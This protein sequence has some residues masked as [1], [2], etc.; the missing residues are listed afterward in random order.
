M[1]ICVCKAVTDTQLRTAIDNGICTRR[2]LTHCFGVGKD[3]GKCNKEV[4]D[5]LKQRSEQTAMYPMAIP[6]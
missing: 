5:L 6:T 1:Y 2:Q 3:C 4:K